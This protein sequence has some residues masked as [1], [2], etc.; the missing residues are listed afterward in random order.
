MKKN[1][2]IRAN[3]DTAHLIQATNGDTTYQGVA[4]GRASPTAEARWGN[5]GAICRS[6]S[7]CPP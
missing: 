6:T 3:D 7:S 1:I 2:V 5:T 4:V